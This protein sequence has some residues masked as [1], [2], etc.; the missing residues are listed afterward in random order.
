MISRTNNIT[1]ISKKVAV[2]IVSYSTGFLSEK[3]YLKSIFIADNF[4]SK[5]FTCIINA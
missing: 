2:Y 1:G 4:A 3:I 5:R